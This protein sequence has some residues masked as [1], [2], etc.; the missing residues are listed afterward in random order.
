MKHFRKT[1]KKLVNLQLRKRDRKIKLI[2]EENEEYIHL[3]RSLRKVLAE[4]HHLTK[5]QFQKFQTSVEQVKTDIDQIKTNISQLQNDIQLIRDELP[6]L[7][8]LEDFNDV[9][10]T[11]IKICNR[12]EKIRNADMSAAKQ[13]YIQR[14]QKEQNNTT[15]KDLEKRPTINHLNQP[16]ESPKTARFRSYQKESETIDDNPQKCVKSGDALHEKQVRKDGFYFPF[17]NLKTE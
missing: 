16:R 3:M 7:N 15:F 9:N 11:L 14:F 4:K 17:F 6:K 12:M 1:Q 13:S 8:R 5:Y 2:N 10:Q